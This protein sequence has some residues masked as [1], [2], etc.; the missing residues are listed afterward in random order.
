M[1]EKLYISK[2]G[3]FCDADGNVV[4]L[5]G[6]NLDPNVKTPANPAMT[7]HF[8]IK[9]ESFWDGAD[10]VS[11]IGH[12]FPL[13][14]VE[15]HINRIKSLGYNHIRLPFTWESL[16]HKGPGIYDYE[17]MD[18][19][20]EVLRIIDRVGGVYVYL[21]PHQDVW[22]RFSG[23]SGAPY[24]TLLAAG[25]Q[26]KRFRKN[27]AAIVHNTIIDPQTGKDDPEAFPR[28]VWATNYYK[29]ACQT[30]FTLFFA[31]KYFAPKCIINGVNI[32]DYLQQTYLDAILTLYKH[33]QQNAPELFESNC[34]IGLESMNEP[35]HGFLGTLNL[36]EIEKERNLRV[37]STPTA[38]QSFMMGEGIDTTIERYSITVFGPQRAGLKNVSC[39][40]EKAWLSE[41]ERNAA[42]AKYGWQRDAGW[43]ADTCIWRLH[44]VW[45]HTAHGPK[46]IIPDYFSRIEGV[47]ATIDETYFINNMF[48]E[49]FNRF[50]K[51]FRAIDQ[52][53]FVLLQP[54]VFKGP[55]NLRHLDIIPGKTI[56]ACHFYDGLSLMFKTWNKLYNV[57]T[58]GIVRGNYSN[59]IFSVVFGERR[60]RESFRDQLR[61]M[62]QEVHEILGKDIPVFFSEIGMPF[63]M[64]NKA[65]YS[66]GDYTSQTRAMNA[67]AYA[68]EGNHLSFSLWCY[69]SENCYKWGDNW[70]NEDFSIYSEDFAKHKAAITSA[71]SKPRRAG[72]PSPSSSSSVSPSIRSGRTKTDFVERSQVVELSTP[73]TPHRET[74]DHSGIRAL[75]ALLR[76][77]PVKI[78]GRFISAGFDLDS[79]VYKLKIHAR[80][81][82]KD[83]DGTLAATYL[84]LP[85]HHF[86][87]DTLSIS[88]SSGTFMYNAEYQTLKWHH[89][90]G[91]QSIMIAARAK[92]LGDEDS[93]VV[94]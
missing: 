63:D 20:I 59:P 66:S 15:T 32:Q 70:N 77:F 86:D 42:D 30:M 4:I 55:P 94:M 37:G 8:P 85:T 80:A 61:M 84:F 52:E 53:S 78:H 50:H 91:K 65:A 36:G 74:V 62:K 60:I 64:N 18:Y 3:E 87:V 69:A 54:P 16:E 56:C 26:P 29:L 14:Q 81:P 68:L 43:L 88:T 38:F 9:D 79:K 1:P 13:D 48:P 27:E 19:L 34:I 82:S 10:D 31:G 40:R 24:W 76:P 44:G 58:F 7:T 46:L 71:G 28:M 45:E 57:N 25:F 41:E 67:I 22:S 72:S 23:G 92:K 83:A 35:N 90:G 17:Y 33:I 12:P 51:A 11:F 5:R 93:C 39:M 89:E 47:S 21:D 49:Y 2:K 6:V 75:D 73:P